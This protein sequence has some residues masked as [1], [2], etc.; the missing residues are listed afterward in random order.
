MFPNED[1]DSPLLREITQQI[2]GFFIYNDV[3]NDVQKMATIL[4]RYCCLFGFVNLL[5]KLN[6][7]AFENFYESYSFDDKKDKFQKIIYLTNLVNRV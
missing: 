7:D 3:K 4:T 2:I 1:L 5:N 6:D